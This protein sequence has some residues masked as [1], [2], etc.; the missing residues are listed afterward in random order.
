M[1][2]LPPV[3]EMASCSHGIIDIVNDVCG[4]LGIDMTSYKQAFF[5]TIP[6]EYSFWP[7]RHFRINP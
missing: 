4:F 5:E 7:P 2:D 1:K 6:Q 3:L